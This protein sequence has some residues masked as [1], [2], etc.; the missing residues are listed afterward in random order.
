M[1]SES[2]PVAVGV[3]GKSFLQWP[4]QVLGPAPGLKELNVAAWGWFAALLVTQCCVPFWH[5]FKAGGGLAAI[6]PSDFVY[7]YGI[8]HIANS[9]PL[10]KLYD[11]G[12]QLKTFNA[13]FPY[14]EHEGNYGPSPYPPFV[15]LFFSLF[16]RVSVFPAFVLWASVSLALYLAGVAAAV[17]GIFPGER[18]KVSLIFASALAF[19]PFLHNNLANGQIST[20]AIFSVGLAT[21]QERSSR[22]FASGLALSMLAYKPTLLLLLVPMLLL[23]RRF[24][25]FAGFVAGS[26]LL[27]AMAT[28]FGGIQIWTA[29]TR[30]LSVFGRFVSIKGQSALV[31]EEYIDIKSFMQALCGGW[32]RAEFVVF[33]AIAVAMSAWLAILLWK[34]AAAGRPAQYLAWAVTLT[35]TLLL[36]VYVPVYDSVLFAIAAILTLGALR[37][38]ESKKATGW[39]SF[40]A[41]LIGVGS[42]ELETVAQSRGIQ[43]LP[44]L[45]VLFGLGQLY[46]LRGA[47]REGSSRQAEELPAG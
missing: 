6:F 42:W 27:A 16:A 41:V 7:F 5:R 44:I 21:L 45:L 33:I 17:K 29:Y 39:M 8:G 20:L 9:Y 22:P 47:I 34:S 24:R 3:R 12:L 26:T 40:L 15:A 19:C 36:N 23:T 10:T 1:D 35:W 13:I 11:Y 25:T 4:T 32:S 38:I 2:R 37:D 18:L 46:I 43:F 30:F 28:A 31:L 14:P